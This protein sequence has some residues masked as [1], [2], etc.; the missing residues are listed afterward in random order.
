MKK[1]IFSICILPLVFTTMAQTQAEIDKALKEAKAMMKN[2]PLGSQNM[3]NKAI[4]NI[5]GV[6]KP[7]GKTDNLKGKTK[8]AKLAFEKLRITPITKELKR[9]EFVYIEVTTQKILQTREQDE[10]IIKKETEIDRH[11]TIK[12]HGDY[13]E[14]EMKEADKL[15]PS[16]PDYSKINPNAEAPQT[17]ARHKREKAAKEEQKK[18]NDEINKLMM[19]DDIEMGNKSPITPEFEI[20]KWKMNG[21][22]APVYNSLGELEGANHFAL[23]KAPLLVP[24]NEIRTIIITC[25][26]V[27]KKTKEK[28]TLET[29]ITLL[30]EGW[31]SAT[32]DDKKYFANQLLDTKYINSMK[33]KNPMEIESATAYYNDG[34]V[35]EEGLILILSIGIPKALAI[36][37]ENPKIGANYIDCSTLGGAGLLM[38]N[39]GATLNSYF[40]KRNQGSCEISDKICRNITININLLTLKLGGLI[41]GDFSGTLYEDSHEKTELPCL[42]S[43]THKISGSFSLSIVSVSDMI[44]TPNPLIPKLNTNNDDDDLVPLV[45]PKTTPKIKPKSPPKKKATNYEMKPFD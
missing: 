34:S 5:N 7:T 37:I 15:N 43:I 25:E 22:A 40:R 41:E 44:G 18:H 4:V 21:L 42:S 20:I 19:Q 13:L 45:K 36:R 31:F 26:L 23:Y 30:N 33:G 35:A 38:Q 1:I 16:N 2:L 9:S 8:E 6:N 32:I 39:W 3:I 27:Y 24:L 14:K 10:L 11:Q 12:E 28:F 29:Q 17:I